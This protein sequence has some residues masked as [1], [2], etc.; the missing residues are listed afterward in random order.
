MNVL[1]VVVAALLGFVAA[2][3]IV[4]RVLTLILA[5]LSPLVGGV[6]PCAGPYTTDEDGLVTRID[7]YTG[8][9]APKAVAETGAAAQSAAPRK[10]TKAL[11]LEVGTLDEVDGEVNL[12]NW[13]M[14]CLQ[15]FRPY[16]TDEEGLITRIGGYTLDELRA[17]SEEHH[18]PLPFVQV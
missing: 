10:R 8:D 2:V 5:K 16:T 18:A 1:W 6:K 7:G 11:I 4:T 17:I 15:R 3:C 14:D 9:A 13:R 12:V